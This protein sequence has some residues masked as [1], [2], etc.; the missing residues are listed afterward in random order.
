[1]TSDLCSTTLNQGRK[2][3]NHFDVCLYSFNR[4]SLKGI[5]FVIRSLQR[6]AAFIVIFFINVLNGLAFFWD[7]FRGGGKIYC[8]ANFFC[9]VIV[10][11]PKF[12][13]GQKF[14]GGKTASGGRP[15]PPPCGRK[16]AAI[17]GS[18]RETFRHTLLSSFFLTFSLVISLLFPKSRIKLGKQRYLIFWKSQGPLWSLQALSR[19]NTLFVKT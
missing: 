7:F 12:R 17:D 8:Y 4:I 1:M 11:G 19:G 18:V 10:F 16:P 15:L 9:Y 14:S 2:T 13:E 3:K 6:K 5:T